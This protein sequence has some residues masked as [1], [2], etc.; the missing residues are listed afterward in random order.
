ML[1]EVVLRRSTVRQCL[2]NTMYDIGACD[3]QFIDDRWPCDEDS[4]CLFVILWGLVGDLRGRS[5]G[6]PAV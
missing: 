3:E 2:S 5:I 1:S 4:Q 6:T